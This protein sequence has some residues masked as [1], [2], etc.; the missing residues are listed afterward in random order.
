MRSK[1]S[2]TCFHALKGLLYSLDWMVMYHSEHRPQEQYQVEHYCHQEPL[3]LNQE[4]F[5]D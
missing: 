4:I 2:L 5:T 1:A 3:Q